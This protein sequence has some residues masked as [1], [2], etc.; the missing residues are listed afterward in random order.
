MSFVDYGL[1]IFPLPSLRHRDDVLHSGGDCPP[2]CCE[3]SLDSLRDSCYRAIV[4]HLIDLGT[5]TE[6]ELL[7]AR[8]ELDKFKSLVLTDE[9]AEQLERFADENCDEGAELALRRRIED[10]RAFITDY[11][12]KKHGDPSE[13][14]EPGCPCK[15]ELCCKDDA[16]RIPGLT[17]EAFRATII[18]KDSEII[19]LK[20]EKAVKETEVKELEEQLKKLRDHVE[21]LE[22]N[23]RISQGQ[24]QDA[25]LQRVE[26]TEIL[27]KNIERLE[28]ELRAKQ[29]EVKEMRSLLCEA[30][31][32]R[33]CLL[34]EL[35]A[36]RRRVEVAEALK[37][38]QEATAKQLGH[39]RDS[40]DRRNRKQEEEIAGC[41]RIIEKLN[42]MY[43]QTAAD[44]SRSRQELESRER[45]LSE[46]RAQ[47]ESNE[48]EASQLIDDLSECLHQLSSPD[49]L[50]L[51]IGPD[52]DG[53]EAGPYTQARQLT[54]VLER[55]VSE[56]KRC[57][58]HRSRLRREIDCLGAQLQVTP[59]R[60][61]EHIKLE[62][63]RELARLRSVL[64]GAEIKAELGSIFEELLVQLDERNVEMVER[65]YTEVASEAS[66][67]LERL[68]RTI[69]EHEA[70]R[71]CESVLLLE[72][73]TLQDL[74]DAAAKKIT[75]L[76]SKVSHE[77]D[78][79]SDELEK[80]NF[81]LRNPLLMI[82]QRVKKYTS[83][84]VRVTA[85]LQDE[86][87]LNV[88]HKK[89]IVELESRLERAQSSVQKLTGERHDLRDKYENSRRQ[90]E[91]LASAVEKLQETS[92]ERTKE[93]QARIDSY[94][95]QNEQ[96]HKQMK[97]IEDEYRKSCEKNAA[98]AK[99]QSKSIGKLRRQVEAKEARI[100]EAGRDIDKLNS[101][102]AKSKDMTA[103]L[104]S[105]LEEVNLK[106]IS[107]QQS[108]ISELAEEKKLLV[109]KV[110]EL[111]SQLNAVEGS[112][113]K[114]Q[115]DLRRIMADNELL[116]ERVGY[117]RGLNQRLVDDEATRRSFLRTNLCSKCD[118]LIDKFNQCSKQSC[119][120]VAPTND[121]TNVYELENQVKSLTEK[122]KEIDD[123][124][125]Q[126]ERFKDLVS[127]A[128]KE[129]NDSAAA[130]ANRVEILNRERSELLKKLKQTSLTYEDKLAEMHK[131]YKQNEIELLK[132]HKDSI[133]CLEAKYLE[134]QNEEGKICGSQNWLQT[135]NSNQ[136]QELHDKICKSNLLCSRNTHERD[137]YEEQ[138]KRKNIN[139]LKSTM[140]NCS[141]KRVSASRKG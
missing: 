77:C 17:D 128:N 93:L 76:D 70:Y 47:L 57:R 68:D 49:L 105:A 109:G 24:L 41:V 125:K 121:A 30:Q 22:G 4:D 23:S 45:K 55:I 78:D 94:T 75:S 98:L 136:L 20:N 99:E 62:A 14:G 32:S 117:L 6:N 48:R 81:P 18:Q 100:K 3:D 13:V 113:G 42:C 53:D 34:D 141:S 132:N 9:Q 82:L 85:V 138:N 92:T 126:I 72:L 74:L 52:N 58:E 86:S 16:Q 102:L 111:E 61:Y 96:L 110:G 56:H 135:L 133:N 5:G 40:L 95:K 140:S 37:T 46:C 137:V 21:I 33:K 73:G 65:A 36:A 127:S 84:A 12:S 67:A 2:L 130:L 31:N 7:L 80:K 60:G 103:L 79:K 43:E 106:S 25:V 38:S 59:V 139:E 134:M 123:K 101:A 115:D 11:L 122:E 116:E 27:K 44:L 39:E 51:L 120:S 97:S 119:N 10:N 83:I 29:V 129:D 64:V 114:L 63:S 112:N 50:E 8:R 89:R 124:N 88:S 19:S 71:E 1:N 90:C 15:N 69:G 91:E 104:Q 118:E 54:R 66:R 131:Q 107:V 35:T 28:R 87:V 26:E 108:K